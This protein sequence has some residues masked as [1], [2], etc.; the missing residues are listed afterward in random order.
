MVV[1]EHISVGRAFHAIR[2]QRENA[3]L[4][5]SSLE[6]G[7]NRS[8][9][10]QSTS[11]H[12]KQTEQLVYTAVWGGVCDGP[13]HCCITWGST[14]CKGKGRFWGLLFP[15]FTMGNAIRLPMVRCFQFVYDNLTTFPFGKHIIGKL[16]SWAFWRY[17]RF[18][19]QHRG[20]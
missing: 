7:M 18:Q 10:S 20:L 8:R 6:C 17:I 1:D 4:P 12:M 3:R 9:G 5:N 14:S 15:I 19:H 16:D 2:P 11:H 13:R